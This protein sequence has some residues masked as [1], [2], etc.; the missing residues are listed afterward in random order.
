MTVEKNKRWDL[1]KHLSLLSYDLSTHF[2]WINANKGT[3]EHWS[4]YAGSHSF[5]SLHSTQTVTQHLC[6]QFKIVHRIKQM[7]IIASLPHQGIVIIS[8]NSSQ[9]FLLTPGDTITSRWWKRNIGCKEV[10]Q[11]DRNPAR[12]GTLS[13]IICHKLEEE[14]RQGTNRRE[15]SH[16]TNCTS[17]IDFKKQK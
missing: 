6:I 7:L 9:V 2:I 17:K 15:N 13:R 10:A 11:R 12:R 14:L 16:S 5:S 3:V 1:R 4:K 8:W